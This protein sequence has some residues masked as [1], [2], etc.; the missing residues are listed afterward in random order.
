MFT[1]KE[2]LEIITQF[3]PKTEEKTQRDYVNGGTHTYTVSP[4]WRLKKMIDLHE[5]FYDGLK[6]GEA[7]LP[8]NLALH[9]RN[10]VE[11]N[12]KNENGLW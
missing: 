4:E 8:E 9:F 5:P 6:E 2:A 3:F 1:R 11:H 7:G 12:Y 10:S